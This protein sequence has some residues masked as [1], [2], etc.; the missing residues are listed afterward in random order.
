MR[1]DKELIRHVA[2]VS[3]LELSEDEVEEFLPQLGQI[4]GAFSKLGKVDTS[5]VSASIH[6]F[7]IAP[8]TR[9]DVSSPSLKADDA[10]M[11]SHRKESFF[12][13]PKVL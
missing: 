5:K 9:D 1:I 11:D 8:H 4:I 2:K 13:G 10:L 3:R 6:P 12:K 7:P